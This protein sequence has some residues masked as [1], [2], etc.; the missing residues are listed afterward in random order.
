MSSRGSK[1]AAQDTQAEDG[2]R[3]KDPNRTLRAVAEPAGRTRP[4]RWPLRGPSMIC[5]PHNYVNG[6][7]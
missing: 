1:A 4:P 7:L 6:N 2:A 5:D 3:D